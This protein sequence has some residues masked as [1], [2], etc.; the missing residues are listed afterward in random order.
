MAEKAKEGWNVTGSLAAG[1]R[2]FVTLVKANPW[3]SAVAFL[4]AFAGWPL[5]SLL[6][7]LAGLAAA[8]LGGLLFSELIPLT[9]NNLTVFYRALLLVVGSLLGWFFFQKLRKVAV[10]FLFLVIPLLIFTGQPLMTT[11]EDVL[12]LNFKVISFLKTNPDYKFMALSLALAFAAAL[13]E[14]WFIMVMTSGTG[15][16]IFFRLSGSK[17]Y[18]AVFWLLG[19]AIQMSLFRNVGGKPAKKPLQ[20]KKV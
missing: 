20:E 17:L 3:E 19:L 5:Y 8:V 15:A 12:H 14:K 2:E 11:K 18:L 4:L 10:F 16:W 1:L 13:F 9:E 6:V 7:R